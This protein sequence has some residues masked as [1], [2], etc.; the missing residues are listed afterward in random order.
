VDDKIIGY[1]GPAHLYQRVVDYFTS[2]G[3]IPDIED[4]GEVMVVC[5]KTGRVWLY[6]NEMDG[7]ETEAPVAIGTGFQIALGYML[8]GGNAEGAVNAAA[9][10]DP[11]TKMGGG[12]TLFALNP[13]A[14]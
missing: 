7:L 11:F 2:G 4:E 10:F 12:M 13:Y 8:G 6:D 5:R 3:D 1:T 9:E 14:E